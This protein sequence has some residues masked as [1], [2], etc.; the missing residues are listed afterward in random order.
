MNRTLPSLVICFALLASGCGGTTA[1]M[2]TEAPATSGAYV[3]SNSFEVIVSIGEDDVAVNVPSGWAV[4]ASPSTDDVILELTK[5][6]SER[7]LILTTG[8][9]VPATKNK[10]SLIC[11]N[12]SFEIYYDDDRNDFALIQMISPYPNV[13]FQSTIPWLDEDWTNIESILGSI[14]EASGTGS[15]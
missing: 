3:R 5:G 15:E 12:N 11:G 6:T 14:T 1:S 10:E 8:Q 2:A 7:H 13:Q 4:A 9:P